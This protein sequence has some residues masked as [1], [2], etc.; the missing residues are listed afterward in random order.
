MDAP[1]C[2]TLL[3]PSTSLEA[4]RKQ[5]LEQVQAVAPHVQHLDGVF[6]HLVLV[7][8]HDELSILQDA[9]STER[10]RLDDLLN[11]GDDIVLPGTREVVQLA[12]QGQRTAGK[13]VRFVLPSPGNTTPG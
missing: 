3:G 11:Y 6:L 10:Q 7:P 8:S 12:L 9:S 1:P 4:K 13:D 2:I 5:L